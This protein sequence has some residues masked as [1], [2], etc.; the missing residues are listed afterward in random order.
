[1]DEQFVPLGEIVAT[2]GLDGWLRLRPLNPD[3][4]TI[5]SGLPV[6]LEKS[7]Q[8]WRREIESS[9]RYKKQFLIKLREVNHID[10]AQQYVGA[11]VL[12]DNSLLKPLAP[13]QYYHFQIVGFAVF[14]LSGRA[15]GTISATLSTP[16]GELYRVQNG[17]KEYLIPA[18]R[19]IIEKV[20]FDEKMVIVNPPEG[21]LDL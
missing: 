11:T 20:D 17:A 2:H 9:K 18:V 16:A 1:M 19:E 21:L 5:T 12:V 14:D 3:S 7:R 15:L 6:H 10:A 4:E 13:G 8:H